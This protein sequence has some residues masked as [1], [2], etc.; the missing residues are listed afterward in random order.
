MAVVDKM[1]LGREL[2]RTIAQ[3]NRVIDEVKTLAEREGVDPVIMRD[4]NGIWV[5][6][7]LLAAKAQ[8]LHA[9]AIINQRDR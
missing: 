5:L 3:I 8:C 1:E 4:K 7:P 6:A 2:F 9:L